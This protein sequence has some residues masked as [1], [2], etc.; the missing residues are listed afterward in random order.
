MKRAFY[1]LFSFILLCPLFAQDS[2]KNATPI[3]AT[4]NAE[5]LEQLPFGD[6]QDF[7]DA[8]QGF[9]G[10][11]PELVI[12]NSRGQVVWDMKSYD[13]IKEDAIA[14]PSVNPSLFRIAQLNNIYGL[15]KVTDGIYQ[16]RGYDIS[17]LTVIETADGIVV[18]DPL[19]C[20]ETAQAAMEL[21]YKHRPKKPVL[22]VIYTHSH[23]DHFGGIYGVLGENPDPKIPI[24]A[25]EGFLHEAVSEN[26]W[27]GMP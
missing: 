14:P 16:I 13:F 17:N 26:I 18:I 8:R 24:V 21:Y 10:N 11:D 6:K 1:I 23:T 9:I 15:F 20:K 12:K 7:K 22:A 5:F 3:T 4:R 27:A 19:T 25:P 2:P